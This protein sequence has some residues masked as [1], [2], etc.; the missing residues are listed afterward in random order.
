MLP[1]LECNASVT[2]DAAR[3]VPKPVVVVAKINGH[4]VRTLIDSGSL[5][6]FL[7]TTLTDQLKINLGTHIEFQYQGISEQH[8]F[9]IMNI[10][11]YDLILGCPWIYQHKVT[12]GLNPTTVVIGSNT[13]LPIEGSAVTKI[14][15]CAM[16]IYEDAIEKIR[17]ELLAYAEPICIEALDMDLLL[18]PLWAINHTVPLIDENKIY[19]WRPSR[20]P[21]A[22]RSQPLGYDYV[23]KYSPHAYDNKAWNKTAAITKRQRSSGKKFKYLKNGLPIA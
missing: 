12:L 1:G 8:Y 20:C 15:L 19:P 21:E 7:S 18:P 23:S 13:S 17:Q 2:K 6:D 22:L 3:M 16:D 11:N 4:S 5:G 14:A 9:D 10:S